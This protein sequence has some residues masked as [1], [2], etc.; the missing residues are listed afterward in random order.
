MKINLDFVDMPY[1]AWIEFENH[2]EKMDTWRWSNDQYGIPRGGRNP[3]GVWGYSD[4]PSMH[5]KFKN[6][7]DRTW[8]VLKWST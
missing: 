7:E 3:D 6:E 2:T 5:Y 8:C 1:I 4:E